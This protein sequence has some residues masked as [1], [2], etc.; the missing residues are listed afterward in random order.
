M[1]PE[2]KVPAPKFDPHEIPADGPIYHDY[3]EDFWRRP[4]ID[5]TESRLRKRPWW[6]RVLAWLGPF[7][8]TACQ[9]PGI[10]TPET[11]VVLTEDEFNEYWRQL[12]RR[13]PAFYDS[14]CVE[15]YPS[16]PDREDARRDFAFVEVDPRFL[17][18]CRYGGRTAH[19]YTSRIGADKWQSGC[20][21]HEMAHSVCHYIGNPRVCREFE[22]KGVYKSRCQHVD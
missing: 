8:L 22:H 10:D 13:W 19:G 1:S 5:G 14:N 15:D 18:T 20:V 17:S 3:M 9:L 21:P 12:E 7:V 4:L 6:K 16:L 11:L 2:T